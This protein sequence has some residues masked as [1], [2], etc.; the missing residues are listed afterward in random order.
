MDLLS[1]IGPINVDGGIRG[2]AGNN[3]RGGHGGIGG[4][5]GDAFTWFTTRN[6]N[7]TD[8][9]GTYQTREVKDWHSNPAGFS[10]SN[11]PDG[12]PGNAQV[13]P[14]KHGKTGSYEFIIEHP[15]GPIKYQSTYDIKLIDFKITFPEEDEVVEPGEKGFICTLTLFNAGKM[16]S[17]I[18][19][20]FFVSV[21]DTDTI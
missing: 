2:R 19:Q 20:D 21:I 14:G 7:Y 5:G 16:P 1:M 3:G 15:A 18:H 17:P 12:F 11:G 10:G 6:E 9:K 4:H 8:E 13:I